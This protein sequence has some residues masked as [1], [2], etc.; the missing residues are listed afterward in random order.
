[1]EYYIINKLNIE[2][3]IITERTNIKNNL[4]KFYNY[5][6]NKKNLIELLYFNTQT[7]YTIKEFD[8][9][10]KYVSFKYFIPQIRQDK[11][12]KLKYI[13]IKYAFPLV[14]EVITELIELLIN[15]KLN[16]YNSLK[17]YGKL[18]GG[19][20]G[21][22]FESLVLYHLNP[23][24]KINEE[25]VVIKFEDINIEKVIETRKFIPKKN[26]KIKERKE[27]IHPE[28][29]TYLFIQKIIT[30][31]AP[32]TLI[33]K[34]DEKNIATTIG[35]QIFIHKENSQIFTKFELLKILKTFKINLSKIYDFSIN[36]ENIYFTYIFDLQYQNDYFNEYELMLN[37]CKKR[38]ALYAI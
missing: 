20:R 32:D 10:A 35:I 37:N 29:G 7:K 27:K 18:H 16:L 4:T 38:N 9:I 30:G 6:D 34:I 33:V 23:I 28:K 12:S 22:C 36:L 31:K 1:M 19:G 3:L 24:E 26:E 11:K 25:K 5:Y 21:Q 8:Y 17:I 14:E 15:Q 2:D 13:K